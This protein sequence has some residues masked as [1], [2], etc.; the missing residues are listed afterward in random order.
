MCC[1]FTDGKHEERTAEEEG[2]LVGNSEHI[3]GYI[4]F[5]LVQKSCIEFL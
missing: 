1:P 4:G 3:K 5:I 2:F